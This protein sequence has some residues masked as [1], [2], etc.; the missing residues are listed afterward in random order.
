M[1][2]LC[3]QAIDDL[4]E[5]DARSFGPPDGYPRDFYTDKYRIEQFGNDFRVVTHQESG[6]VSLQRASI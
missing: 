5:P 4:S 1:R 3:D 2:R 6:E